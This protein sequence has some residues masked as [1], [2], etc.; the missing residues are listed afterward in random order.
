M[1]AVRS[2]PL[3]R[4]IANSNPCPGNQGLRLAPLL[5]RELVPLERE[6]WGE[7]TVLAGES[8]ATPTQSPPK[9]I[10]KAFRVYKWSIDAV[11]MKA[12]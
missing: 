6:V 9:G 5:W 2:S 12:G 11:W 10:L 7:V 3:F 8:E 1:P 4:A